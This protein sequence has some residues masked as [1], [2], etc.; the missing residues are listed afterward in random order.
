MRRSAFN[1][2]KAKGDAKYPSDILR[3]PFLLYRIL[4]AFSMP[5]LMFFCVL[6]H[7]LIKF[8]VEIIEVLAV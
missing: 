1:A 5:F 8:R 4:L 6:E 2:K 7:V 3:P